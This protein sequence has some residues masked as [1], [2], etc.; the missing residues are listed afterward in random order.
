MEPQDFI[1]HACE[2][3]LRFSQVENWDNLSE[4]RKVQLGFNMWVVAL[5]LNLNKD[6]GF[7]A[8]ANARQSI[9]SMQEFHQHV[10]RLVTKHGIIVDNQKIARPF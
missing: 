9:I 7:I 2:Q 10:T 6:D 1:I 8:L 5:G 4:E 3:V